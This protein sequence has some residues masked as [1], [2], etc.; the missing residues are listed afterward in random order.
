MSGFPP[1]ATAQQPWAVVDVLIKPS[2]G[3]GKEGREEA[4]APAAV[5][6]ATFRRYITLHCARSPV[7][8]RHHCLRRTVHAAPPI[9]PHSKTPH[10]PSSPLSL[11]ARSACPR[12]LTVTHLGSPAPNSPEQRSSSAPLSLGRPLITCCLQVQHTPLP[13]PPGF[14]RHCHEGPAVSPL[15]RSVQPLHHLVFP[16]LLSP[17]GLLSLVGMAL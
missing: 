11:R 16:L 3:Q 1:W 10:R 5:T 6:K 8:R 4:K 13:P 7:A 17:L 15:P 12:P 9:P 2:L 14:G